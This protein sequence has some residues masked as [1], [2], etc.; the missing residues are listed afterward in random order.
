MYC[1]A[2][3]CLEDVH[4]ESGQGDKLYLTEVYV[5]AGLAHQN[6]PLLS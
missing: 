6:M 5:Y 1:D 2:E 4:M 3:L